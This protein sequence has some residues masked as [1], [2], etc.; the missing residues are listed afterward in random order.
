MAIRNILYVIVFF[1]M[2]AEAATAQ[3]VS[4]NEVVSRA[5]A[6]SKNIKADSLNILQQRTLVKSSVNLPNPEFFWESPTGTFY[7]GS[8]TQ[9]IEFPTVYTKQR[10]VQ[11]A[12]VRL[13][14]RRTQK[15]GRSRNATR[16]RARQELPDL[17]GRVPRDQTA[18]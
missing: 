16:R 4:E 8:I 9:S 14:Q 11:R 12:R 13:A 17:R 1:L 2:C 7:T 18:G 6:N 15:P 3:F 5:L 10:A